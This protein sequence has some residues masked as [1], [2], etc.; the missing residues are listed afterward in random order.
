MI[1]Y[2]ATEVARRYGVCLRTI[3]RAV[4]R[5][6]ITPTARV[7]QHYRFTEEA[8][9]AWEQRTQLAKP[10]GRPRTIYPLDTSNLL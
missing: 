10:P 4:A 1:W 3:T 2:T 8:L 5:G 9:V 6:D 7:H